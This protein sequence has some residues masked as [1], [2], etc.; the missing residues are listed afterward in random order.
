MS[1]I[2]LQTKGGVAKYSAYF[3]GSMILPFQISTSFK[4]SAIR[5]C[6]YGDLSSQNAEYPLV[7]LETKK[8]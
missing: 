3:V 6:I 5:Q 2:I 8:S 7:M 1:K 4:P